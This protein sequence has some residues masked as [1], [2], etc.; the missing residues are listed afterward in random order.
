MKKFVNNSNNN[1]LEFYLFVFSHRILTVSNFSKFK[2]KTSIESKMVTLQ[3]SRN[4]ALMTKKIF[5]H[6]L[7]SHKFMSLEASTVLMAKNF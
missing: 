2:K 4:L 3:N 7:V 1:K 6:S 5:C